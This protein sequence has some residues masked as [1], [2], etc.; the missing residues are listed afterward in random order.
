[1]SSHVSTSP[2]YVARALLDFL[3]IR[4]PADLS[5]IV[6]KIGLS[7]VNVASD[8][9]GALVRIENRPKG[10]IGLRTGMSKRRRRFTIAHEIGHYVLPGHGISRAFCSQARVGLLSKSTNEFESAAN[11]FAGEF[12]LPRTAVKAMIGE[13][14]VSIDTCELVSECFQTS[15]TA[16][17][18]RCVELS[19]VTVA[20][21]ESRNGV[22]RHVKRGDRFKDYVPINRRFGSEALANQLS[23]DQVHKQGIVPAWAWIRIEST[24]PKIMEDSLLIPKYNRVLTLLSDVPKDKDSSRG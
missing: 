21:V 16:A 23:D 7:V 12:L 15:F 18:V 1:M 5:T 3:E 9:E 11:Q 22:V 19:D 6:R 17:A 10:V 13:L 4:P 8:F 20:L 24:R 14:G 2:E